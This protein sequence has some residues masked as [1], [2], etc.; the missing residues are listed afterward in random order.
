MAVIE[1]DIEFYK[2]RHILYDYILKLLLTVEQKNKLIDLISNYVTAVEKNGAK[3]GVDMVIEIMESQ[4][5][6]NNEM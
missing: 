2:T 3:F 6:K 4:E 1:R 5:E